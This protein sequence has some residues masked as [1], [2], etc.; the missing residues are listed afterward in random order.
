MTAARWSIKANP[1]RVRT[2]QFE[3]CVWAL[4]IDWTMSKMAPGVTAPGRQ[5]I[6]NPYRL[7][8]FARPSVNERP[9]LP[10]GKEAA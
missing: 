9:R 10:K 2:A 5:L 3:V 1:K 4:L 7:P 6:S 8:F